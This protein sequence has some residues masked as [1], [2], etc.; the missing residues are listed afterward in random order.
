MKTI[1]FTDAP[2]KVR[3]LRF[4]S[5]RGAG[6]LE[7]RPFSELKKALPSL[8]MASLVYLD[9]QGLG[10]KA[11]GRLFSVIASN[12]RVRFC[13]LDPGA[14]SGTW[15]QSFTPGPSTTWARGSCRRRSPQNAGM[16][17]STTRCASGSAS[18][19]RPGRRY[20]LTSR[21]RS[22]TGG[23]KSSPVTSTPSR[24]SSSRWTTRKS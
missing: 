7:F 18:T 20:P 19:T 16:R 9:V 4:L 12:P 23:R 22:A 6:D 14:R 13:V 1:V 10:E 8:E 15:P 3:T 21:R 5:G 2:R 17:H 24:S 11:R